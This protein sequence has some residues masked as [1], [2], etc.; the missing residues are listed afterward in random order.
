LGLDVELWTFGSPGGL[1]LLTFSKCWA[2]PPHL[3][4]VGLQ[5]LEINIH[6]AKGLEVFRTKG[7]TSQT[8][9]TFYLNLKKLYTQCKYSP[10]CR[11][12][13]KTWLTY[14]VCPSIWEWKVDDNFTR[15]GGIC[16]GPTRGTNLNF[17]YKNQ[18]INFFINFG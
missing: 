7:L 5:H 4:K 18:E 1:Q 14:F 13:S 15:L 3:A 16:F 9:H 2:S 6:L 17:L 12:C 10:N 11:Y 8:C